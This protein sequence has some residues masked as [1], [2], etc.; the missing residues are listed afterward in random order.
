VS[1]R[2][3]AALFAA[4]TLACV[5]C[6]KGGSSSFS[7]P[8]LAVKSA[9]L[10]PT[11]VGTLP[12]TDVDGF[13][14]LLEQLTGTPV[15]VNVWGSWCAPCVAEAPLL[16]T[17][18]ERHTDIQFVGVDIQDS[19]NG[20]IAFVRDHRIPYPSVFDPTGAIR[21]EMGSLGQP[22]TYFFDAQGKMVAKW[23]GQIDA[24]TL[25]EGLAKI[26]G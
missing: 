20:A 14:Q 22:D 23:Q 4:V 7:S 2:R 19:R 16:K 6:G 8:A 3:L 13:H 10:L 25:D 26:D 12:D 1:R 24:Q 15:V 9:P 5:A 17:A 11:D 21:T 18:A